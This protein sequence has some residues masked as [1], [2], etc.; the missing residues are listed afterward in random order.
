MLKQ[1]ISP[2]DIHGDLGKL[3]ALVGGMK[4]DKT[5]NLLLYAHFLQ[6]Y[7]DVPIQLLKPEVDVRKDLLKGL[8]DNYVASRSE[9]KGLPATMYGDK[10]PVNEIKSVLNPNAL[11]YFF[12][13]ISLV[14]NDLKEVAELLARIRDAGRVVIAT[15]LDKNFRGEPWGPMPY[16]MS[17]AD[18]IVKLYGACEEDGCSNFGIYSQRVGEDGRVLPFDGTER[19]V[20]NAGYNAVCQNHFDWMG[21]EKHS[22]LER[23][24]RR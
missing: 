17:H 10:D 6:E 2:Q 3:V 18:R 20:G 12:E 19:E 22:D 4:S 23:I 7:A 21:T 9:V 14:Q 13:E 16:V 11:V 8:P 15:G 1:I 5:G 24:L